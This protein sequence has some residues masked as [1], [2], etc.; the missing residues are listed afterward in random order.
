[1]EDEAREPSKKHRILDAA[2]SLLSSRGL[3]ALSFETVA[4]EAGLSRQLVRY[5]F[6]DLDALIAELCDHLA[7]MYREMLLSGIVDVGKAGKVERLGFFLDFF[8]DLAEEHPMPVNLEAY[9]A[10]IAYSVGSE[11]LRDRMCN[12]YRTLGHVITH[13]LAI[14][15]PQLGA[16]ACEELSFLFVSM[17]HAHWSFVASLGYSRAHS[18]LARRAFDRLIASYLDDASDVPLIEEPWARGP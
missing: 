17:M 13:E 1:M 6:E 15:H 9:D 7:H 2:A 14:A 3:Q 10:M 11:E 8:F 16:A 18:R 12:Q 5:Y 4:Q